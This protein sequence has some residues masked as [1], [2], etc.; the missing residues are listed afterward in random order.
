MGHKELCRQL[1]KIRKDMADKLGIDLH[2]TECTYPGECSGTCPKCQREEKI[3]SKALL[4]GAI[5]LSG[6]SLT[7]C[8]K[9]PV[10]SANYISSQPL[11]G[12]VQYVGPDSGIVELSGDVPAPFTDPY[13]DCDETCDNQPIPKEDIYRACIEI[14]DADYCNDLNMINNELAYVDCVK[15]YPD[16]TGKTVIDTIYVNVF[17]GTA[18]RENGEEFNICDYLKTDETPEATPQEDSQKNGEE[19]SVSS[20]S[21]DTE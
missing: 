16:T 10:N 13:E 17:S 14:T 2:Q 12:D 7:A 11:G 9:E 8:Q 15:D 5:A 19:N 21:T 3:L 20:Q 6:I 1:K 18:T 4:T